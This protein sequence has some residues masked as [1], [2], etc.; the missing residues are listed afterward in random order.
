MKPPTS[1]FAKA[2]RKAREARGIPQE[3][4][5]TVSSR[6]YISSLERGIKQPTVSKVDAL[7]SV[8]G[9]HPLT[10][11]ALSYTDTSSAADVRRL[12]DRVH[13][14]I[15]GVLRSRLAVAAALPRAATRKR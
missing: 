8:L 15:E 5:D 11:F 4:F 6:T 10:L 12:L 2:L 7:A 9:L 13:Q 1:N 14:E 3:E